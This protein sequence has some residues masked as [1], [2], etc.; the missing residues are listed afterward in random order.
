MV[1]RFYSKTNKEQRYIQ[2]TIVLS[3]AIVLLLS[4]LLSWITKLYF[5]AFIMLAV[6]LSVAASFF[7]VPSLYKSGKLRY[8][9]LLLLSEAPK[10]GLIKVHGGTLF[11]YVFVLDKNMNGNERI[12]FILK[13]YIEGLITL[14][15]EYE[16]NSDNMIIQGTSYIINARTA[17][18]IGFNIV[19][20][21]VLQKLILVFNY[22]N[23]TITYS[24]AKGRLSFP[25]ISETRTFETTLH[26]L[27][28][29]KYYLKELS[30][31]L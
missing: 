8:H 15:E 14:I 4:V 9:S 23:I 2:L 28:M 13:Q 7:D 12:R 30:M 6:T 22:I 29:Q 16:N 1:H 11:D 10:D 3:I 5:I 19:K 25:N 26:K 18:R 20:T 31:R 24:F 21:D 27:K 17:K